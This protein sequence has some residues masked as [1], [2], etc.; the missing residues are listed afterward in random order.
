MYVYVCVCMPAKASGLFFGDHTFLIMIK[1]KLLFL[2]SS[3]ASPKG[4]FKYKTWRQ[5]L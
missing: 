4:D 2:S 3:L 1:S 5:S